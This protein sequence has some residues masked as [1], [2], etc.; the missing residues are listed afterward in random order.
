MSNPDSDMFFFVWGDCMYC[1]SLGVDVRVSRVSSME[2]AEEIKCKQA[3]VIRK[4]FTAVIFRTYDRKKI[5]KA[6][7]WWKRAVFFQAPHMVTGNMSNSLKFILD[8][9]GWAQSSMQKSIIFLNGRWCHGL[10]ILWN[11]T[12]SSHSQPDPFQR[13]FPAPFFSEKWS[14]VTGCTQWIFLFL[15]C[16]SAGTLRGPQ[17]STWRCGV[18]S[19]VLRKI[20]CSLR[21]VKASGGRCGSVP[22]FPYLP[23]CLSH[24]CICYF[25]I[26]FC[27]PSASQV[28]FQGSMGFA[29]FYQVEGQVGKQEWTEE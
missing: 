7:V 6:K 24:M 12:S 14:R 15:H 3:Y 28:L 23:K 19:W 1:S 4:V 16:R 11:H 8:S 5:G 20:Q 21:V 29:K 25:T 22:V 18:R 27:N 9:V 17:S 13:G 26:Q 2:L 10:I